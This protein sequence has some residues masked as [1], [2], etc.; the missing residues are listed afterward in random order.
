MAP[1]AGSVLTLS[2]GISG[3]GGLYI[4]NASTAGPDPGY[5]LL[6]GTNNYTGPTAV[7]GTLAL[8]SDA[9]LGNSS[10]IVMSGGAIK[11]LADW[12]TT[13]RF[14]GGNL[15][16]SMLTVDTNG[17]DFDFKGTLA[18]TGYAPSFTKK[19]DGTFYISI[20]ADNTRF[21][22]SSLAW[23]PDSARHCTVKCRSYQGR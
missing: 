22:L 18:A 5:T 15:S 17:H 21:E 8:N 3:P 19:G 14:E 10:A 2:G 7:E 11:L 20:P 13:R 23:G 1:A 6:S 12:A 9:A 4:G 16:S